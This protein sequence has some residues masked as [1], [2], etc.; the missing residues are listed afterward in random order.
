MSPKQWG[1]SL[2]YRALYGVQ[3]YRVLMERTEDVKAD[4]VTVICYAKHTHDPEFIMKTN[5]VVPGPW[6]P[7]LQ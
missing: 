1:F 5:F 3:H 7:A 6:L 2:R 4:C